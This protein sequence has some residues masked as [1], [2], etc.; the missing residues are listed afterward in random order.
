MIMERLL[1]LIRIPRAERGARV[2]KGQLTLGEVMRR[3]GL[4]NI[5]ELE[6]FTGALTNKRERALVENYFQNV[7]HRD[8]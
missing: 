3:H 5:N 1:G 4:R 2:P 7:V 8:R 6:D